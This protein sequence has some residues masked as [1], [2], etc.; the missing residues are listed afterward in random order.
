MSAKTL[1]LNDVEGLWTGLRRRDPR[2]VGRAIS[3][4]LRGDEL[5][6]RI[7]ERIPSE[8]GRA[9]RTGV[10]GAS[11]AG[12]STLLAALARALVDRGDVVGIIASDPAS[13]Y[14]GGAFLGDRVRLAGFRLAGEPGVF[15]RSLACGSAEESEGPRSAADVLDVAGYPRIFLETVG[16]GQA[17]TAIRELAS[18][19]VLVL[20]PALG[21]EVQLLK[22]GILEIA[23]VFVVNR[24]GHENTER[25]RLSLQERIGNRPRAGTTWVPRIVVTESLRGEGIEELLAVLQEHR[26]HTEGPK[27]G[28]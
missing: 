13:P 16:A 4:V 17:D 2:A 14:S 28:E 6:M 27:E 18:T 20:S 11:G 1:E 23:D 3:H 25:M 12:K 15:F 7:R 5:G 26:T 8:R 19:V 22:A 21:D 10:T 24:S 9:H